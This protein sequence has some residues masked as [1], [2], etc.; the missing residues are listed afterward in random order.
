MT[1]HRKYGRF[2]GRADSPMRWNHGAR[3]LVFGIYDSGLGDL[4]LHAIKTE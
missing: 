1:G 4:F 3:L 2:V